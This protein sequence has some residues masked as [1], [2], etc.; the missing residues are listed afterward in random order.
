MR[1]ILLAITVACVLG[2]LVAAA[3]LSV[4]RRQSQS[5][6]T[7]AELAIRAGKFDLGLS[8][9]EKYTHDSP[10]D[11]HGYALA[12]EALQRQ[13][14]FGDACQRLETALEQSPREPG[15]RLALA[16]AYSMPAENGLR[17][18][19]NGD[20]AALESGI[21]Q[22]GRANGILQDAVCSDPA[23]E[24]ECRQ[25][26]AMNHMHIGLAM[27]VK[28]KRLVRDSETAKAGS[29]AWLHEN[30]LR[31]SREAAT[32]SD[33]SI[34]KA[35][36][37]FIQSLEQGKG[38]L[39]QG[40]PDERQKRIA[41]VLNQ[42][43]R[44]ASQLA[45]ARNDV[46]M[47]GRIKTALEGMDRFAPTAAVVLAV[48]EL[49]TAGRLES[50]EGRQKLA[51]IAERLDRLL[52]ETASAEL[53]DQ[54]E[55]KIAR[56]E[57]ALRMGQLPVC[58]KL[59]KDALQADA[60]NPRARLLQA[61]I[62]MAQGQW[63]LAER[64]LFALRTEFPQWAL[65]QYAYAEAANKLGKKELAREAML[66]VGQI[67]RK[68]IT[69]QVY[70]VRAALQEGN[71]AQA[72]Q[73]AAIVQRGNPQE[74]RALRILMEAALA[75]GEKDYAVKALA[76]IE[77]SGGG[78]PQILLAAAQG[79][80]GLNDQEQMRRL[81]RL[82]SEATVRSPDDTFAVA[83]AM[84]MLGETAGVEKILREQLD[85][86][87]QQARAH[88]EL[89][90]LLWR[91]S[92]KMQ[93]ME[94]YRAAVE[95]AEG[96]SDYRLAL[97]EACLAYGDVDGAETALKDDSVSGPQAE[98]LRLQIQVMRGQPV[99]LE[100]VMARA[101]DERSTLGAAL[102]YLTA[103]KAKEC[104]AVCRAALEK[105]SHQ[106]D[107]R[108][109]LA[110]GYEATGQTDEAIGQ[111]MELLK[112][113]PDN[114]AYYLRAARAMA[115]DQ[116]P[117]Q[118][119]ER[120][121]GV[122][123]A[124]LEKV[125]VTE[126]WLLASAGKHDE[127]ASVYR[128]VAENQSYPIDAQGSARMLLAEQL[129]LSGKTD[130]AISELDRLTTQ[131]DCGKQAM[132]AKARL[133]AEAGRVTE[134][135][136][137]LLRLVDQAAA[138]QDA[139]H[140]QACAQ[141]Y[142]G[143]GL[144]QEALSTCARL[145]KLQPGRSGPVL[146]RAA[147]LQAAKR[148]DEAIEAYREVVKSQPSNLRAYEV[149]IRALD[150]QQRRPE[151]LEALT[152][153][154]RLGQSGHIMAGL[155]RASV[156][157]RWGLRTQARDCLEQLTKDGWSHTP[158]ADLALGRAWAAA[159]DVAHARASLQALPPGT[160]QY[161]AAQ[162]LLA[163]MA[164]DPQAKLDA[165]EKVSSKSPETLLL[166]MRA[167][168]ASGQMPDAIAAFTD[169]CAKLGPD[170][171]IPTLPAITALDCM[172]TLRDDAAALELARKM[173]HGANATRWADL[174]VLLAVAGGQP[175]GAET[176][177]MQ[178]A[179]AYECLLGGCVALA[180][181]DAAAAK[182]WTDQLDAVEQKASKPLVPPG[183]KVL[184]AMARGD[185]EKAH[186]AAATLDGSAGLGRSLATA[187]LESGPD[188]S[189]Q[190]SVL[191][192]ASLA[193]DLGA[194]Q[195]GRRWAMDVLKSQPRCQWAAA[196]A[197]RD[198]DDP[199]VLKQVSEAFTDTESAWAK[200]IAGRLL[201]AQGK[202]AEAAEM[203]RLARDLDMGNHEL[204]LR[205]ALALEH[206]GRLQEALD[207]YTQ[208]HDSPVAANNAAFLIAKLWPKE[209]AHL[210]D[211][212]R[213]S[214]EAVQH[215]P[216]AASFRDTQ[217]WIA[218]L[219]GDDSKACHELRQA[220]EAMPDSSETHYHLSL[221]ERSAGNV[222]LADWHLRAS[223]ELGQ[224]KGPAAQSVSPLAP[225]VVTP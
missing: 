41:A 186:L 47:L 81:A 214:A 97:A 99:S 27:L 76:G 68:D 219:L 216:S 181:G 69:S 124:R 201:L 98:L 53:S 133:L 24:M 132:L 184:L 39:S 113:A 191:L 52:A 46:E 4:H 179:G 51:Q 187:F 203:L 96:N 64:D 182:A 158:P 83:E 66:Q 28:S 224:A 108:A 215:A 79:Y 67:D 195:L 150:Q 199:D 25:A 73:D 55:V 3:I 59:C 42:A 37:M 119:A 112:A 155:L 140:L 111:W 49:Q 162:V 188:A 115:K 90:R 22:L 77:S 175:A 44:Y 71:Y 185:I 223:Q 127:A 75:A 74:P 35:C 89:G 72:F 213:L 163:E 147:L 106:A 70:L 54:L 104:I 135:R 7:R 212:T 120:L 218:H 178:S 31:A 6:L 172:I 161:E 61:R 21:A 167:Q 146:L 196:L 198:S 107:L 152:Q 9:A 131:T 171:P 78:S 92:R 208:L 136:A 183:H 38:L 149:L 33:K 145:E 130:Q 209:P 17:N 180:A 170:K 221:A 128:R 141:L 30:R 60:E 139:R 154:G 94:Q 63:D 206:S 123:G 217:G 101:P 200:Q 18:Q 176:P 157:A 153:M 166:Q 11:W 91:S 222:E 126:A 12:A 40:Q 177:A 194:P 173:A 160:A 117:A 202:P 58:E 65:V 225:A 57:V 80:Q 134:C 23:D 129:A 87:G 20:V 43:G 8:L 85:V 114:S 5:L 88:Y 169:Y 34:R 121:K 19:A 204:Q 10:K 102:R 116:S 197:V 125:D 165:L 93:A 144:A 220:V 138:D 168:M 148:P 210:A 13:G 16:S 207:M 29:T 159:G 15:L 62:R 45:V 32:E 137:V 103:G 189:R 122:S 1:R 2:G 192:R 86:E 156:L 100:Q 36:D 118:A 26:M 151:V 48:Y 95:L 143:I 82:A 211:A 193:F 110:E 84:S 190:A 50:A 205:L 109:L 105:D 56:A 142:G 164:D 14:R 174:A